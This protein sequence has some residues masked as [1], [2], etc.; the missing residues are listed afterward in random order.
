MKLKF[1]TLSS[2]FSLL[3]TS[4]CPL[5]AMYEEEDA[6]VSSV[7]TPPAM[8]AVAGEASWRDQFYKR[9]YLFSEPTLDLDAFKK[10]IISVSCVPAQ[11]QVEPDM[12]LRI[13]RINEI[14]DQESVLQNDDIHTQHFIY[15]VYAGKIVRQSPL[16]T[17]EK[18]KNRLAAGYQQEWGWAL[19]ANAEKTKKSP[20]DVLRDHY[21]AANLGLKEA[22]SYV[23]EHGAYK[24]N[25]AV[26]FIKSLLTAKDKNTKT[27]LIRKFE[28]RWKRIGDAAPF[29][30]VANSILLNKFDNLEF[31]RQKFIKI[32]SDLNHLESQELLSTHALE[33]DDV[34]KAAPYLQNLAHHGNI[35]SIYNFG[36]FLKE[37]HQIESA[38]K[39]LRKVA[40]VGISEAMYVLG[41]CYMELNNSA[42]EESCYLE[43]ARLGHV[44]AQHNLGVCL[45]EKDPEGAERWYREAAKQGHLDAKNN[46]ANLLK[47]KGKV[48]EGARLLSELVGVNNPLALFNLAADQYPDNPELAVSNF[49]KAAELGSPLAAN[50]LGVHFQESNS[51]LAEHYLKIAM[52]AGLMQSFHN[53]GNLKVKSNID[54][55]M[56][57]YETAAKLGYAESMYSLG[58]CLFHKGD[59]SVA[60]FWLEKASLSGVSQGDMQI[61]IIYAHENN[62]KS[63]L[64]WFEKALASGD[65]LA[66]EM[67]TMLDAE[68]KTSGQEIPLS[69]NAEALFN[70]IENPEISTLPALSNETASVSDDEDDIEFELQDIE[71]EPDVNA[72]QNWNNPK[73]RREMLRQLGQLK[74]QIQEEEKKEDRTLTKGSQEIASGILSGNSDP[75]TKSD[76]MSLFKDPYFLG[77]V[78]VESTKSGFKV[79]SHHRE[80]KVHMNAG[81][82]N[83][84]G[85]E[86]Y[87]GNIHP[88][89]LGRISEILRLFDV[90]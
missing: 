19:W 44:R 82:H 66:I 37:K 53:Y 11:K 35:E 31:V 23:D 34:E 12:A 68:T 56:S 21:R 14:L 46:L 78:I 89:T 62:T 85:L 75:I 1:S 38:I 48:E 71:F 58:I 52:N 80:K 74:K 9:K 86:K 13:A 70:K 4:A 51:D 30:Q 2:V 47:K 32:A 79:L 57:A 81:A 42:L 6:V 61:A 39:Y 8:E 7:S 60:K 29:A 25:F 36:N 67:K 76:V 50:N 90:K 24:A 16:I 55:A 77:Q 73:A 64:F 63:F 3:L 15:Q 17:A 18:A 83:K 41:I 87:T 10:E 33:L 27:S 65:E 26:E 43:A 20:T 54:E 28:T 59:M 49:M 40:E 5:M 72:A 22:E 84:H 69:E 45:E 88:K